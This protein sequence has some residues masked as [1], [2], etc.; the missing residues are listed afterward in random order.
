MKPAWR[1]RLA[2]ALDWL[3]WLAALACHI[4][5]VA[6]TVVTVLQVA[7]RFLFNNPTSWSEEIA[8]LFLIWFGLLAVA[9]GIRRHEHVAIAF[10]RDLLPRPIAVFLDYLAQLAMAVFMFSVMY[11]GQDL[12]DLTGIQVLPASGWPKSLL[13]F[14][15]LVGGL[16][17]VVNA[18]GNM[19][20]RDVAMPEQ[21]DLDHPEA[22]H[23]G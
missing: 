15:A 22:H 7:L 14:P 13:Y 23:V 19:I 20:L 1:G 21:D 9:V 8:L 10:L 11:Y 5:L 16:L 6:I 17:G 18:L 3:N 4:L 12:I 2:L